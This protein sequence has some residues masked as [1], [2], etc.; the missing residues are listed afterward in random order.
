MITVFLLLLLFI[1]IPNITS[2][3]MC[4]KH[5]FSDLNKVI[6]VRAYLNNNHIERIVI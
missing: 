4:N 6:G 3:F 2:N 5:S 1:I